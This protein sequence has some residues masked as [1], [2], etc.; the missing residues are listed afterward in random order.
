MDVDSA[1]ADIVCDPPVS[2]DT[3]ARLAAYALAICV[4]ALLATTVVWLVATD[5]PTHVVREAADARAMPAG[6]DTPAARTSDAALIVP[7]GASHADTARSA[8]QSDSTVASEAIAADDTA[9][10]VLF[11][12][13]V[14]APIASA[15]ATDST[16]DEG[17]IAHVPAR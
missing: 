9:T 14:A 11:D 7:S 10:V 16:T 15:L 3:V 5:A 1:T 13:Q 12:V 8:E 6:A 2:T 4:A 17:S